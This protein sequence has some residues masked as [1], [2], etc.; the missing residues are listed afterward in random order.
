ML[1]KQISTDYTNFQKDVSSEIQKQIIPAISGIITAVLKKIG[2]SLVNS[3]NAFNSEAQKLLN[4]QEQPIYDKLSST[5]KT[6]TNTMSS[7]FNSKSTAADLKSEATSSTASAQASL[8]STTLK[9][10][11]TTDVLDTIENVAADTVSVSNIEAVIGKSVDLG[12][13]FAGID[14]TLLPLGYPITVY[15]DQSALKGGNTKQFVTDF[16]QYY[17]MALFNTFK[18]IVSGFLSEIVNMIAAAISA[19]VMGAIDLATLG[20]GTLPAAGIAFVLD[21]VVSF[22]INMC[23]SAVISLTFQPIYTPLWNKQL[24]ELVMDTANSLSSNAEALAKL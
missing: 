6:V 7:I 1:K 9:E 10:T 11:A 13:V 2:S 17:E 23:L 12:I 3:F 22:F 20:V 8:E 4:A 14:V 21:F 24:E 16:V 19:T 5:W 18:S 15:K